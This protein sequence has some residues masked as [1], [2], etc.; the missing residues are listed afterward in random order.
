MPIDPLDPW[1]PKHPTTQPLVN[2]TT[3]QKQ[4]NEQHVQ[5]Y[6]GQVNPEFNF[7]ST[8]RQE[9]LDSNA[10][11]INIPCRVSHPQYGHGN[12]VAYAR[13]AYGVESN[14]IWVEFDSGSKWR[15]PTYSVTVIN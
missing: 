15:V 1:I 9:Y 14:M 7:T 3:T 11:E 13:P 12:A 5:E 6:P 2:Q 8:N 10:N 4:P